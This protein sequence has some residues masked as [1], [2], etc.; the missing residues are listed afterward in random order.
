MYRSNLWYSSESQKCQAF[1]PE[2][3]DDDG[4]MV[5]LSQDTIYRALFNKPLPEKVEQPRTESMHG[6]QNRNSRL[7]RSVHA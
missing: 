3:R 1:E 7:K 6:T 5:A 4:Y 2:E